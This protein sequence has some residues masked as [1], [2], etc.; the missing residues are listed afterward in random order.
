MK[1]VHLTFYI[2]MLF[3]S[4]SLAGCRHDRP[5]RIGVSQCSDDDWRRKM[6][7]EILREAMFHDNIEVEIRSAD[8]SNERQIADLKYFVDNGFDIIVAAPNEAEALTPIIKEIYD[9]GIP[10]VLFDRDIHGDSYTAYQG[11]DNAEI[12]RYAAIKALSYVGKGGKV[13]EITGL[14]GSTPAEE[15]KRGFDMRAAADGLDIVARAD[16]KWN[17]EEA[18]TKVDSLLDIYPDAD[19]IY[20]HNDRMA[21]AARAAADGRGLRDIKIIGIDA[22]PNIGIKAVADS[23]IDATFVY[24]TEGYQLIRTATAILN[25][26]PFER[27]TLFRNPIMVDAA[28]AAILLRQDEALRGETEKINVLS[29]KIDD[30]WKRHSLQTAILYG[31]FVILILLA[32]VIFL[33]MRS[34]WS[35]RR[36]RIEVERRNSELAGQKEEISRLYRQLQDATQSKLT[37][38]TNVSHDLRTPLTLIADPVAQLAE[39]QNLTGG[40]HTLMQ[41][42]HKNVKI[43]MRLINQILD[44]RKFDNG[45]LKLRLVNANFGALLAEWTGA[46][47]NA[48]RKRHIDLSLDISTSEEMT[49]A[50]DVDKMERVVFNLIS[51]AFKFTPENGTI[52]ISAAPADNNNI[53]IK[54][55]DTGCGISSS[56]INRVFDRFFKTDNVNPEGSGIGLALTKVFV[57]MHSGS[58][59][60]DSTEGRGTVFTVVLPVTHVDESADTSQASVRTAEEDIVELAAPDTDI[61]EVRPD[62]EVVLVIDDNP[63]ICTLVKCLLADKYTVIQAN[64]G[65]DGIR[66]ASKH[67]PDLI[68]CDIMMPG[69]D[70]FETCRRIKDEVVT[71]HIPVLLL[72]ACSQDVERTEGYRCGADGYMSK[73][74]D[75]QMLVARCEALLKNRRHILESAGLGKPEGPARHPASTPA[76]SPVGN[77]DIDDEFYNRFM[78]VVEAEIGNAEITVEDFAD[79]LGMSRVQ[80][81]RKIKAITNYSPTEIL[82]NVR[83]KRAA[84]LLK[85]TGDNVSE[86]CYKVGFATPSYFT[87]CY[88]EYFGE[89]PSDTQART[90]K[91]KD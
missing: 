34:Y 72:T 21:V 79:R 49:T 40:Q 84:V 85:T 11:A 77:K 73:P 48:A 83:L 65:A 6:N 18:V 66:K 35:H 76:V 64:S 89:S 63:D 70:G 58:I 19:L 90:S 59:S 12:G 26:E 62:A 87:K 33:L 60:V 74:F 27:T 1:H 46:F 53:I 5:M 41:L 81:Y 61:A 28:N 54:V 45:Q 50:V 29:G 23:V 88:R 56:E 14:E 31:A 38:F 24:P 75:S 17:Y 44:I 4:M 36:H 30:F 13:L 69:I 10:V 20:A 2:L 37:F 91:A 16:G 8:D 57:E 82:R 86:I 78:A 25:G 52:S 67:I 15:R 55:A 39:A 7:E 51:N 47:S 32:V 71:S 42:A 22:A 68:I 3:L 9:S 80:M 43:L